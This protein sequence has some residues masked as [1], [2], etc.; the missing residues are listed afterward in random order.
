MIMTFRHYLST[1][2]VIA[3]TL[4][5]GINTPIVANEKAYQEGQYTQALESFLSQ[6]GDPQ[7]A[8]GPLYYNIGNTYYKQGVYA[9]AYWAYQKARQYLPRDEDL[10]HNLILTETQLGFSPTADTG[11]V[12]WA[13]RFPFFTITEFSVAL[14]L[15]ITFFS[16]FIWLKL[17]GKT[18]KKALLISAVCSLVFG[19]GTLSRYYQHHVRNTGI[20]IGARTALKAGPVKTLP[21]LTT[22]SAGTRVTEIRKQDGWTEIRVD[23]GLIGWIVESDYWAL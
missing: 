5:V 23:G 14:W 22:L 8:P 19:F 2:F 12:L 10:Y 15:S 16:V 3:V 4:I 17:L 20:V 1:C 6:I 11:I 13:K 18:Y 9:K 21:T 7:V